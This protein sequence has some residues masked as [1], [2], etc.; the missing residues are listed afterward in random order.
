MDPDP[1]HAITRIHQLMAP[2]VAGTPDPTAV[3][4]AHLALTYGQLDAAARTAQAHLE[5]LGLRP[6]DRLLV[7]GE[8]CVALC[9]LVLAASRMDVWSVVANA[10]RRDKKHDREIDFDSTDPIPDEGVRDADPDLK[11]GLHAAISACT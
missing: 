4:D 8:N 11:E 1:L 3:G 10:R 6:G 9:V 5:G 2:W 7:V